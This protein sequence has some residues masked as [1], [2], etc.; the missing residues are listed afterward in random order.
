MMP[1]CRHMY[2]INQPE[3][4]AIA[5]EWSTI[6]AD[7]GSRRGSHVF[8]VAE[9]SWLNTICSFLLAKNFSAH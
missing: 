9:M 8:S 5:R 4:M 1:D 6:F 7:V 3:T 2:T